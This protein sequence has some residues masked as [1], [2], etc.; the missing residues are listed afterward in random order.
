MK[1]RLEWGGGETTEAILT[2]E[3]YSATRPRVRYLSQDFVE[4]LCSSD[5]EGTELQKAIEDV[6]FAKL[7][8]IQKEGYSSFGELR[9]AR[10]AASNIRRE[11]LRGEL[12]TLHKEVERLED[13]L[14]QRG[15]K[16]RSKAEVEKQS[17]ELKKQLPNATQS[18]DKQVLESLELKQAIQK[19]IEDKISSRTRRRRTIEGAAETYLGIKKSTA[20]EIAQIQKQLA[21][22]GIFVEL[23]E[24]L[25]P[26]WDGDAD[27]LLGSEIGK[28][29]A[30]ISK[31]KGKED[32]TDDM[33]SL[34][35]V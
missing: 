27:E 21:A 33:R 10:E 15:L 20:Q 30:E 18:V 35:A 31:L 5:L 12:A 22:A 1:I 32:D 28:L 17:E 13:T 8:E 6:V 2:D 25:Q 4:R 23:I 34:F 24:K 14:A 9:N 11:G 7:D 19:E 3:P 16:V 29:E 26:T